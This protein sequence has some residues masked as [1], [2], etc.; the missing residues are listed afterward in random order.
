MV[1]YDVLV[2]S[3]PISAIRLLVLDMRRL[4]AS[5]GIDLAKGITSISVAQQVLLYHTSAQDRTLSLLQ[6]TLLQ[7]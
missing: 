5:V 7:V 6:S 2:K 1:A 4:M 3:S